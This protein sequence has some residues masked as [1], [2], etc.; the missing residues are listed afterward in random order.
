MNNFN[1][2]VLISGNGSTLQA[3]ID[4]I[5]DKKLNAHISA[6]ISNHPNVYGLERAEKA[7]IHHDVVSR[8]KHQDRNEYDKEL[9][10]KIAAYKPDLIVLAGFM[11][12]LSPDFVK[13]FEGKIIN[14]HPSL[15][16]HYRGV[17]TYE[18]AL[19]ANETTHGTTIHFVTE[20]LDGGPL[21]AQI[22]FD[23]Q[24]EDNHETLR[25]RTQTLERLI[26]PKVIEWLASK[27]L[28]WSNGKVEWLNKDLAAKTHQGFLY[29][30]NYDF[31]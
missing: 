3:I 28:R 15:L 9:Q 18:R 30:N 27:Q 25:E 29:L 16:P 4:A 22:S 1:I 19:A 8:P 2:V 26:Y 6:V 7:G 17:N 21:I 12:I 14:I 5:H 23:I 11:H 20:E 24:P 13:H 10:K 31:V